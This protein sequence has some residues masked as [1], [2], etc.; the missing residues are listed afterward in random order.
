MYRTR[1]TFL[2]L[3]LL[4][5]AV[6][7]PACVT[8]SE[9][10]ADTSALSSAAETSDL[11]TTEIS[12]S[13]VSE[14]D[15]SSV[16]DTETDPRSAAEK[17]ADSMTLEQQVGQIFFAR[18]PGTGALEEI[19]QYH[20]GGYILFAPDFQD[21][22]PASA[23][24]MIASYQQASDTPMLIGVDEEG[25]TVVRVSRFPAFRSSPFLSPASVYNKGG[26]DG[27]TADTREKDELLKSLGINVNLGPVCDVS[28]NPGD[29]IYYR[30]I[31]KDAA[32]TAQCIRAIVSQMSADKMGVTLKHFPGYGSNVDTHTGIAVDTRGIEVFRQSEFLPFAAGI[33]AGADSVMVNHNII[34]CIDA[35]HPATLSPAV[36]QVLRE[37]LGFEGVIMTDDLS[38]QAITN[39]TDGQNAAVSAVLAGNDMLISSD[40]ANQYDA[41]LSAVKEGVI[42][43]DQIRASVVRIINWK[44]SMGLITEE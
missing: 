35:S 44:M 33:E 21:Q 22:T 36:H 25:G 26:T 38:M 18:C 27:L 5:C 9:T 6:L 42:S 29:F 30:T 34:N 37:E 8:T 1:V 17:Y 15:T 10:S 24:D 31:G 41:V 40:F 11:S 14:D 2:I 43:E 4:C 32:T 23:A 13:E 3:S 20:P 19:T 39:W 28:Q 16:S 12:A 7:C